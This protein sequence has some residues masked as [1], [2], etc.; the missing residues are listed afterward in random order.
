MNWLELVVRAKAS[1]RVPGVNVPVAAPNWAVEPAP[2]LSCR[3]ER[4]PAPG[5]WLAAGRWAAASSSTAGAGV[6]VVPV[7]AGVWALPVDLAAPPQP[8]SASRQSHTGER[9]HLTT[10][11]IVAH[12]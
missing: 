5:N 1:R 3:S 11:G 6:P 2:A 12:G 10:A 4:P 8:A 9:S 7:A